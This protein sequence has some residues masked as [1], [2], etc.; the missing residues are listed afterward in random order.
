M[1][2]TLIAGAVLAIWPFAAPAAWSQAPTCPASAEEAARIA[3]APEPFS[4][5][6]A[7]VWATCPVPAA[8]MFAAAY[9]AETDPAPKVLAAILKLTEAP[10]D[11]VRLH[12]FFAMANQSEAMIPFLGKQVKD[13]TPSSIPG[14]TRGDLAAAALE[15]LAPQ[16]KPLVPH[17]LLGEARPGK[18]APSFPAEIDYD[19]FRRLAPEA[20]AAAMYE[21]ARSGDPISTY[22]A[23]QYAAQ[24]HPWSGAPANLKHED[25]E[26]AGL[27]AFQRVFEASPG[28]VADKLYRFLEGIPYRQEGRANIEQ[29]VLDWIDPDVLLAEILKARSVDSIQLLRDGTEDLPERWAGRSAQIEET[30][31]QIVLDL[32]DEGQLAQAIWA[33]SELYRRARPVL[34]NDA[35][36][37]A[38]IANLGRGLIQSN[39]INRLLAAR[40]E[41]SES[42]SRIAGSGGVR[43][44]AA[45]ALLACADSRIES[46]KRE[47]GD[48]LSCYAATRI[49]SGETATGGLY[50][51][52]GAG[53][54]CRAAAIAAADPETGKFFL[55]DIRT[56]I[57]DSKAIGIIPAPASGLV[58]C[59]SVSLSQL[60]DSI[61]MDI[62]ADT[63]WENY[64]AEGQAFNAR[65]DAELA[66]WGGIY[67]WDVAC[68]PFEMDDS[69]EGD[70]PGNP[71]KAMLAML[72]CFE[73][74]EVYELQNAYLRARGQLQE[75]WIVKVPAQTRIWVPPPPPAPA[76]PMSPDPQDLPVMGPGGLPVIKAMPKPRL[77]VAL[78]LS[79]LGGRDQTLEAL[80]GRIE[81]AL[82]KASPG[83]ETGLFSDG[84]DGIIILTR[85]ERIRS[86][87]EPFDEARRFTEHG[88][89]KASLADLFSSIIRE[90]PGEFR[91]IAFVIARDINFDPDADPINLPLDLI[92]EVR[93]L[94][95]ELAEA[96]V[97][98]RKVTAL[99]YVFERP[100]GKK[101]HARKAGPPSAYQHLLAAGVWAALGLPK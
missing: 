34:D 99:V 79:R 60:V 5:E 11:R 88:N 75:A 62:D 52:Y 74:R 98:D 9:L 32:L 29:A 94:P 44:D 41:F 69:P 10:S 39:D 78:D 17:A 80:Q 85:R 46:G 18:T 76:A 48:P 61:L 55:W 83:Y 63:Y 28:V 13:R 90:K 58:Q 1:L 36:A 51:A 47:R 37:E 70:T 72:K 59:G 93:S 50:R 43:A 92:G 20:R 96:R 31:R 35:L 45:R 100:K 82:R 53:D 89:P 95:P 42:L 68:K 97:G 4:D 81:G 8:R 38:L 21:A 49:A 101:A 86:N 56:R 23:I 25:Y 14:L 91:V 77:E 3:I 6:A 57:R 27:I 64:R 73:T 40:P 33:D 15:A 71:L 7:L 19:R 67:A 66:D 24:H 54:L 16:D 30:A 22:K 26:A 65:A 12:A 84:K 87:G 2:R